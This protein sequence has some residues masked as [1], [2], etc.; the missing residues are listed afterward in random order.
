[1]GSSFWVGLDIIPDNGWHIY[2]QNPGDSGLAPKVKWQ[3]PSSVIAGAI[4]WP[5]PKRIDDGPLTSYGYEQEVNLLVPF[6]IVKP[7]LVG[8]KL[9]LRAYLT[10]LTCKDICIPG[11]SELSL[12]LPIVKDATAITFNSNKSAFDQSQEDQPQESSTIRTDF[13]MDG[14]HWLLGIHHA[15]NAK[16]DIS[17]YPFRDDVIEHPAPEVAHK[18]SDGYEITL[19]KSHLSQGSLTSLDGI[20]VNPSG[21]DEGGRVKSIVV[22]APVSLE[23]VH[24]PFLIACLF[25]LIGGLILNLMPC[26]LPVLSI[27]VLHLI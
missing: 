15:K 6:Q 1:L 14:N 9:N 17:F 20:A 5:Y 19:T 26:V 10:W 8:S 21:W 16:G 7:V 12:S 3:L 23:V 27:K 4:Q 2:W 18:T 25:A 13:K 24:I 22:H 11:K